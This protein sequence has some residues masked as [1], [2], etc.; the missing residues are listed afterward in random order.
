MEY[1]INEER[2]RKFQIIMSMYLTMEY[3]QKQ[4]AEELNI[5]DDIVGQVTRCGNCHYGKHLT[6]EHLRNGQLIKPVLFM[7]ELAFLD[8]YNF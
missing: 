4:I 7:Y 1:N 5:P 8:Y 2:R 3:T 6:S